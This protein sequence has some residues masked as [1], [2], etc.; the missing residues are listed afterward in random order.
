MRTFLMA[1]GLALGLAACG[2]DDSG[3]GSGGNPP[4]PAAIVAISVAPDGATLTPGDTLQLRATLKDGNGK[5]LEGRPVS[6][7][8]EDAGKVAV[9]TSGL[10]TAMSA[11]R[12]MVQATAEG[13]TASA[14]ILVE[15]PV[16]TVAR[17]ELNTVATLLEEGETIALEA[18]AYDG[19]GRVIEGRGETWSS[20]DSRIAQVGADGLVTALQAGIVTI[21]VQIDDRDAAATVRVFADYGFHLIYSRAGVEE[22][23]ELYSLNISDPAAGPQTVF[24]PGKRASHAAPSPDGTRIAFVVYGRWDSTFWQSM[25][26]VADRDGSN[27]SRLTFLSARNERPVWSPDGRRI[28]FASRPAG[29]ASDIWVMNADGSNPVNLTA[30]QPDAGKDSPAWSP[31]LSGGGFRIAYSLSQDGTGHLWTMRDDGSDKRQ[32]TSGDVYD[33]EPAWSPD[34][35]TLVFTRSATAIFGDLYLV[36]S[37]GGGGRA[38]MP[39]NPLALGQFSPSWSPDGRLI[40]FTSKHGGSEQPQVWTVWV[41]GTRLAQRTVAPMFHADPT[42]IRPL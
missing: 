35:L 21:K 30:D 24:G 10:V 25:I 26:Y 9:T 1:C 31:A 5:V 32:V 36:S 4:P 19:A 11:G 37:S 6:W 33:D 20:G 17:V 16:P 14:Q 41:D 23:E 28:A 27:A 39:A 12:V 42:W 40:A 2:G 38:L 8:S 15:E 13:K 29:A 3:G 22:A 34:G 18:T 7:S